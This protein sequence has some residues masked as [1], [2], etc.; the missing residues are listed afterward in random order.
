MIGMGHRRIRHLAE[1]RVGKHE[2]E[3]GGG[4]NPILKLSMCEKEERRKGT[5]GKTRSPPLAALVLQLPKEGNC[6]ARHSLETNITGAFCLSVTQTRLRK[7]P[8]ASICFVTMVFKRCQHS[9]MRQDR[10]W[11][12]ALRPDQVTLL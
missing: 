8:P 11:L 5:D 4:G 3:E 6:R 12:L 7:L 1:Q 2:E 9:L 10:C